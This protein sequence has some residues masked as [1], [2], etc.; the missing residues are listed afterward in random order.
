MVVQGT[1]SGTG[2]ASRQVVLQA[3]TFP[4][5]AGFQNVGNPELTTATGSFTFT[6]LGQAVTT[7]YRVVT[8]TKP[9]I[10]SPETIENVAVRIAGHIAR[11]RKHG[12]ARFYGT[13][14]PAADRM[15]VGILR[16]DHGRYKLVGGSI[17]THLSTS[18]SSFSK[19]VRVR[20]G[21]YRVLVKMNN[22]AQVS[23]YSQPLLI[24]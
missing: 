22:G 10:V 9:P 5:T 16:I 17:L 2:N 14:A 8:T 1:L 15:Q 23:A 7:K 21:V 12:F 18:F 11:T 6:E 4:F 13:V 19:T 3:D 20:P 24:R